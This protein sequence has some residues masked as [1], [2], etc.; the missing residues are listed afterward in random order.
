VIGNA[1]SIGEP[2]DEDVPS[3]QIQKFHVVWSLQ[4]KTGNQ[5]QTTPGC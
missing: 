3:G 4:A 2:H 5:H 1:L